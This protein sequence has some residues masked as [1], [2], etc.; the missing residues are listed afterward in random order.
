MKSI[1]KIL[2]VGTLIT[3]CALLVSC[4]GDGIGGTGIGVED[5]MGISDAQGKLVRSNEA[6]LSAY[7]QDS[8]KRSNSPD[9]NG[10]LG[11]EENTDGDFSVNA[12]TISEDSGGSVNN[13]LASSTNIQEQG[14]DEADLIKTDGRFVFSVNKPSNVFFAAATSI[15]PPNPGEKVSDE[16]RIMDTQG[17]AGFAEVKRLASK[18][19]SW[20]ISGIYLH[21]DEKRLIALSSE[22]QNYYSHWFESSYFAAQQ[23]E[24][25]LLD[26]SEPATA[27]IEKTISF[28][29]QLIDSRR[30][31]DTLYMVLRHFPDYQYIDDN[32]LASTTSDDF[33][34]SYRVGNTPEQLISKPQNCF[35]EDGQKGS[36]DVITLVA[37]D[38][39]SATPKINS[40]CYV[41]NVEAIYASQ[42]SLYLATTRWN[43]Q[44]S[45]G[46]ADYGD[47]EVTTDIHKFSYKGL[48][49]DYRGSGEVDGHLGHRQ[50]SKS[51]R[52]SESQDE[53]RV[54]TFDED[55]WVSPGFPIA[56]DD[57][58]VVGTETA[59]AV[60]SSP[61]R[62]KS[63]VNSPVSLSILKE[64]PAKKALKLVSKLPNANRPAPI[65]LPGEQLYATRFIGKRAY[66]VTFRVTDPLYVLDLSDSS[67]PFI[68][69]ELKVDG[70]SEILQPISET[71][72]LGIGKDAIPAQSDGFGGD[73]RGAWYQGVKLSLI[74][75]SDAANPREVDKTIIGK[76]GTESTALHTH[77]GL[78]TLKVND[79]VRLALP[80]RLHQEESP[81]VNSSEPASSY[82]KYKQLGLYR[83]E[84]DIENQRI[85]AIPAMIISDSL[86]QFP[87]I[88]NDRSVLIENEVYYM[89]DGKF[90]TQDWQGISEI[91]GPK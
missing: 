41:G 82:H 57:E 39:K 69:G 84:I 71:L 54:I 37:V 74:D 25:I 20:N 2:Y 19:K 60:S 91:I 77:H 45:N 53:L 3:T 89:H 43:Y 52:F 22:N 86:N 76:R 11:A 81:V 55:L 70:Y 48:D 75:V 8:I 47:T 35:L 7:F 23:T 26:V 10:Q 50:S 88:Y 15:F 56:I 80:V 51:F 59:E 44:V 61:V 21:Q 12:P 31:G 1:K 63:S 42:L 83:Y 24:V 17:A 27:A 30:N 32:K 79:S 66:V 14:V 29:G 65:G 90:W 78:T 87:D 13:P 67:D 4:G 38:L 62:A 6:D 58:V 85:N 73:G 28:D 72:L 18:D 40:Q 9:F 49:F 5:N 46:I 34:P 16:I 64:D 36:V 33:L 68:A